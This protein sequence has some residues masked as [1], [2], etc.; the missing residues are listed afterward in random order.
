LEEYVT[1]VV[2]EVVYKIPSDGGSDCSSVE[3]NVKPANVTN[4]AAA[5]LGG[6]P[7]TDAKPKTP[8]TAFAF[9]DNEARIDDGEELN[10]EKWPIPVE[11]TQ[12]NPKLLLGYAC[13]RIMLQ[14]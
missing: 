2:N 14:G 11:P 9:S 6:G 8:A 13:E 4:A 3:S 10:A 1:R 5:S 7:T 12:M